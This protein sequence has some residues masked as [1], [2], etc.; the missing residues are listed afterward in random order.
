MA[1]P[2]ILN[3][4]A[5]MNMMRHIQFDENGCV[6]MSSIKC[7]KLLA[8][9]ATA[10]ND[11]NGCISK[12]ELKQVIKEMHRPHQMPAPMPEEPMAM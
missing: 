11:A 9:L 7:P 10:D 1:S 12:A 4:G 6:V 8:D 2:W 3:R 5:H